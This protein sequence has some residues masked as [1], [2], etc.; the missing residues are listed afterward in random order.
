MRVAL[1]R[2]VTMQ[3][4]VDL[5]A[6]CILVVDMTASAVRG[7]TARRNRRRRKIASRE[8]R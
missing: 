3:I 4:I 2:E 7:V 8:T 1:Q 6:A 5:S